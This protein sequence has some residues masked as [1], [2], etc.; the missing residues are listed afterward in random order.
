MIFF[1]AIY[2]VTSGSGE[3]QTI[4][5]S[6]YLLQCN[7]HIFHSLFEITYCSHNSKSQS[8][9]DAITNNVKENNLCVK[10]KLPR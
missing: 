4:K 9:D 5:E 2:L 6:L 1:L 10:N 8:Q 7:I 3:S